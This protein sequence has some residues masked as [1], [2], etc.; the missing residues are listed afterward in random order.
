VHFIAE[1]WKLVT[2]TTTKKCSAKCGFPFEHICSNS[3]NA[4]KRTELK[5]ITGNILWFRGVQFEGYTACENVLKVCG[6]CS[7]SQVLEQQFTRPEEELGEEE[8]EEKA[9]KCVCVSVCLIFRPL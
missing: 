9:R 8:E 1:A 5:K 3:D 6:D 2:P 4:L 7:I